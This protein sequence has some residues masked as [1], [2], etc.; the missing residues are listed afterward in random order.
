VDIELRQGE[1]GALPGAQLATMEHSQ[2]LGRRSMKRSNPTPAEQLVAVMTRIYQSRLTTASG[3]NLS[4]IDEDGGLWV[5][6]SQIDKG[7]LATSHMVR[8]HTDGSWKSD[9]KPTSE[10]P[11]HRAVLQARPDCRAVVHAHPTSL[12]A[13]SVV[14]KPLPLNQ[15][16]DL[17]RWVNHVGF[18]S[19]AIPGSHKLGQT[20]AETFATGCDATLMENHGAVAC[21]RNLTEAFYRFE[22]LEH[23]ATILLAGARLGEL[24]AR[25]EAE[26]K[27]ARARMSRTWETVD[28]DTTAQATQ[29]DE[30]AD[31]VRRSHARGLLGS[32]AGAFSSRCGEGLLIAPD[33][34][35]N[36]TMAAGDLVYVE[37]DRC[38][39]GK[40]LSTMVELHQAIY[41]ARPQVR[42][43]ATALPPNL[44]AFAASGVAFDAR[45]IPEA[46]IFLKSVPTLPFAARFD[47]RQV[48]EVLHEKAPV[49]LI[50]SACAVVTGDS[51][52]AVFDRL[53]VADFTARSILDSAAI[54][55]LKPMPDDVLEEIC[56]VYGC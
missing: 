15:F 55:H 14:G 56:Q 29:R 31:Y 16:P 46:Y 27:D 34:T 24:R 17:Y 38:E 42:S 45:T 8:I 39:A 35:D 28:V 54:G 18:S 48:A 2:I 13:F 26:M 1:D 30:L 41:R 47:G 5:T 20:S 36:A 32:L 44:M 11:F 52:F 10:W 33:G 22:A 49:A 7:R 51:P 4:V 21:G 19:Y 40:T 43:I 25:G 3:G 37:G 53:E 23:L 12:V 9:F 6:P 50:D